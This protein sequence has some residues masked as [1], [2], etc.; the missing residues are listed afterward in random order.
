MGRSLPM[1]ASSTPA[2]SAA[3]IDDAA[4]RRSS[5]RPLVTSLASRRSAAEL[6]AHDPQ[7][8]PQRPAH[9]LHLAG[10]A[11]K[12]GKHEQ[13]DPGPP[14]IGRY[15]G[16]VL[17][18]QPEFGRAISGASTCPAQVV[19]VEQRVRFAPLL[20]QVGDLPGD[21]ALARPVDP[22]EQDALHLA[23]I[24][25]PTVGRHRRILSLPTAAEAGIRQGL[26]LTMPGCG[27][28]GQCR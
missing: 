16:E 24:H 2:P 8:H 23:H 3:A 13:P 14:V 12:V 7:R 27:H 22:G 28:D 1:A 18:H 17:Q 26:P 20:Q 10:A 6:Q 4:S 21:R 11:D 9:A 25:Q 19:Q 5:R 15:R